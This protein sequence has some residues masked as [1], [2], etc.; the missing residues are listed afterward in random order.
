MMKKTLFSLVALSAIFVGCGSDKS[1]DPVASDVTGEA[2][3]QHAQA[4]KTDVAAEPD[5]E[6]V[7][8]EIDERTDG[9]SIGLSMTTEADPAK[10]FISNESPIGIA[11]IGKGE[12]G[13]SDYVAP[14]KVGDIVEADTPGGIVKLKVLSIR[15]R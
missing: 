8:D 2:T 7:D 12:P 14:A 13:K 11:L 10:L 3:L 9:C 6:F 1:S 15:K 5:D 4:A